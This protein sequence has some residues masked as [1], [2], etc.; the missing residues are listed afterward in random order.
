MVPGMLRI[1][2]HEMEETRRDSQLVLHIPCFQNQ[3]TPQIGHGSLS[4][5][6]KLA[7]R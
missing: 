4:R 5:K 2:L 7:T 6:Q 1:Q 3:L